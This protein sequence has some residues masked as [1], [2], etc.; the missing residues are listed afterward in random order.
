MYFNKKNSFFHGVMFHHFHDSKKHH[1]SQGSI[2][3]KTFIKLIKFIGRKNIINADE[4]LIKFKKK[5]LKKNDVC[6]TF[7]DSLK[8]QYDIAKPVLDRFNIKAFFF[9]YTACLK[10][11]P[12]YIELFRYFRC[13]YYKNINSFYRDFFHHL[14]VKFKIIYYLK[15]Q[16]SGFK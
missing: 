3:K 9:I 4:F 15:S 5:K 14:E 1:K 12:N 13:R 11:K 7:D 2:N 6:L 10:G 16:I 8:C